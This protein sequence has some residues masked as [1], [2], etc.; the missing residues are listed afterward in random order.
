MRPVRRYFSKEAKSRLIREGRALDDDEGL[1]QSPSC[2]HF[3]IQLP[4]KICHNGCAHDGSAWIVATGSLEQ[5][6]HLQADSRLLQTSKVMRPPGHP[7]ITS[8]DYKTLLNLFLLSAPVSP[9]HVM[10]YFRPGL[11]WFR[12]VRC[13]RE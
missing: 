11:L 2:F 9:P 5:N 13:G 8:P 3:R 7:G 4:A 12:N 1:E 10:L 6:R